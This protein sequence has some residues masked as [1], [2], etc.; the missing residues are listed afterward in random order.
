MR[1][2]RQTSLDA[3]RSIEATAG[4]LR[5]QILQA[6][7]ARRP[8]GLTCAEIETLFTLRHQTASAR[9]TELHTRGL[10]TDSDRR[11]KTDSGRRAI[12]WV[13]PSDALAPL[14]MKNPLP[15]GHPTAILGSKQHWPGGYNET[16]T[17]TTCGC[18]GERSTRLDDDE[19]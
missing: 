14:T 7:T 8:D 13:I 9:L 16:I 15:C 6:I 11:R 5:A 1:T 3:A 12:V 17:C 2:V 18:T 10:I 4:S 19:G